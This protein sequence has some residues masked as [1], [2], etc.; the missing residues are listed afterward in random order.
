[1]FSKRKTNGYVF[2]VHTRKLIY[3]IGTYY[4]DTMNTF[5]IMPAI[6]HVCV[7]TS[8]TS[9]KCERYHEYCDFD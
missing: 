3:I 6:C 5:D 1:M 2:T 9:A 4:I 7:D 8:N